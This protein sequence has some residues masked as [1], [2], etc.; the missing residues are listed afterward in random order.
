MSR[1]TDRLYRA[2]RAQNNTVSYRSA[3]GG[4]M[5]AVAPMGAQKAPTSPDRRETSPTPAQVAAAR[6]EQPSSIYKSG[7]GLP[8]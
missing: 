7:K 4:G 2:W 3:S 5:G 1:F 8:R 6:P